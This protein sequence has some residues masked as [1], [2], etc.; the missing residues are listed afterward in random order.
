MKGEYPM[1]TPPPVSPLT[2]DDVVAPAGAR[3]GVLT[4]IALAA[5][6]LSPLLIV[7]ATTGGDGLAPM[8]VLFFAVDVPAMLIVAAILIY[9]RTVGLD[10]LYRRLWVGVVGGVALTM[11]LDVIR[12][13]GVRLGYL[14]DSITMFGNM[15]TDRMAM[16]DPTVLSYTLGGVYHYLNGISFGLIFSILFGLTQW[17]G[18]VLYSVLFVE[19]GMMTLPPMAPKF[20]LF[21]LDKYDSLLNGYYLTTLLAHLAMGLALAAVIRSAARDRGILLDPAATFPLRSQPPT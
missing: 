8:P 4:L 15:I 3:E 19:T 6:G 9:A 18:P 5:G 16:A 20:G 13:A 2:G 12:V 14:P 21:G 7:A 1:S 17:W 10:R 11:A